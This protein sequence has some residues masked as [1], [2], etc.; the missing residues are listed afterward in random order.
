[1]H[2]PVKT[3]PAQVRSAPTALAKKSGRKF[4]AFPDRIDF[5]D[6]SYQP[7][8]SPIPDELV[9]CRFVPEILN[10]GRE[11]ACTGFALA[12]V[13][14]FLLKQRSVKRSVSPRML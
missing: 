5:R 14:N 1:M 11:G 8:L 6:W 10:Q 4:D 2:H 13:I 12:A 9:N 3:A 7:A